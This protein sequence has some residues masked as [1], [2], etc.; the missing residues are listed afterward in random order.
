MKT[1]VSSVQLSMGEVGQSDSDVSFPTQSK[2][3]LYTGTELWPLI[4]FNVSTPLLQHAVM[5]STNRFVP[6]SCE[7]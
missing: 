1:D 2:D 6:C 7:I 4:T 3:W 5:I